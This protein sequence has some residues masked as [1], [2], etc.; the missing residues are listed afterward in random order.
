MT[1]KME[2]KGQWKLP[3]AEEWINGTLTFDPEFGGKL[4]LFGTF[5]SGF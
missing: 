5:N 3:D 2:Y 4:E 1:T